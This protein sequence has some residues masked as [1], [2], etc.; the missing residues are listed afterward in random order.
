MHFKLLPKRQKQ[1]T[2]IYQEKGR[3]RIGEAFVVDNEFDPIP[4]P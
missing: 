1:N 2:S 3:T 4:V